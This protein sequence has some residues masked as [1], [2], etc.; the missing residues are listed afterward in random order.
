M[1]KKL[2]LYVLICVLTLGFIC[3]L[4]AVT[5]SAK[6]PF[7]NLQPKD[8]VLRA[9]FY[10]TYTSSSEERKNNIALACASLNNTFVDVKG[11]FSFNRTVGERTEKR[12]YKQAKIIFNGKFIEGVGGGV[13]QV[14]STLYNAVLLAGLN[15]TESHP[16]SLNVSYVAPSFDAMVNSGSSDFRFVNDTFNPIIIKAFADG[17]RIRIQIYGEPMNYTLERKSVV[18]CSI[19]APTEEV[20]EDEKGEYPE[21]FEGEKK[22][23]CYSK[24]GLK[25]E[26]YIIKKINGIT[27]SCKKIREDR[28]SPLRGL[29]ILG[30]SK[31][32]S[33]LDDLLIFH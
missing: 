10:T 9:Q 21:L 4:N 23:V 31:R 32:P 28:Y 6:M 3:F 7:Y 13:C 22:V 17:E 5:V 2:K 33:S 8:I 12:G 25:S 1:N 14:S 18:V 11:E 15:I 29:V 27:V 20:L 30:K 16:H 26:G 24:E 19:P